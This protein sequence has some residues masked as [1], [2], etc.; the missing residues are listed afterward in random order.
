MVMERSIEPAIREFEVGSKVLYSRY[1]ALQSTKLAPDALMTPFIYGYNNSL[2]RNVKTVIGDMPMLLQ[3][4]RFAN[5]LTLEQAQEIFDDCL[6]EWSEKSNFG[7]NPMVKHSDIFMQPRVAYI[8]E[9]LRQLAEISA[10]QGVVAIVDH[11][12]LP[13]IENEWTNNLPRK[14]RS[15]DDLLR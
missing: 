2:N 9:V 4:E 14:L 13:F 8:T 15:F 3:R 12:L 11:D 10:D 7:F 6:N 5:S 1:K